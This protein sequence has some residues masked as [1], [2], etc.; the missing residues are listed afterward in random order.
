MESWQTPNEV[1]VRVVR[2]EWG[3]LLAALTYQFGNLSQAEDALQDAVEVAYRRWPITG[4]QIIPPPG[5]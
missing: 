2:D 1:L 5:S 4:F 3:R